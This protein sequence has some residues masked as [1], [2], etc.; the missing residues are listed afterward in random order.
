MGHRF[1]V[2]ITIGKPLRAWGLPIVIT[3]KDLNFFNHSCYVPNKRI[4]RP[5]R[6]QS[7]P[8]PRYG[9]IWV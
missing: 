8:V 1:E 6:H 2:I 7:T 3:S 4:D 9:G 5:F